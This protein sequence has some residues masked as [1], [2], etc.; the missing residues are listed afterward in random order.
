[1]ITIIIGIAY[2]VVYAIFTVIMPKIFNDLK[3]GEVIVLALFWPL[4]IILVLISYF[5]E[6]I[7]IAKNIIKS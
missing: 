2:I 7:K 5:K 1:M 4:T 6:F 3:E